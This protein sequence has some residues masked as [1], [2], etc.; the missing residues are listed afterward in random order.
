VVGTERDGFGRHGG[1]R[2]G[3]GGPPPGAVPGEAARVGPHLR[4]GLPG[5]AVHPGAAAAYG[6]RMAVSRSTS[7]PPPAP[8]AVPAAAGRPDL[9]WSPMSFVALLTGPGTLADRLA[10]ARMRPP[11]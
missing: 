8:P 1:G 5:S 3:S 10:D 9:L 11:L 4:E 7:Q 2:F 6:R